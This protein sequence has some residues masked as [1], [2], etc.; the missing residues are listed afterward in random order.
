MAEKIKI[1]EIKETY[2]SKKRVKTEN[3][4]VRFEETTL[5]RYKDVPTVTGG[6][7]FGH[8][9][10]DMVIYYIFS[11]IIAVPIVML[12]MLCGFDINSFSDDSSMNSIFDRLLSWLA[13]YPGYYILFESTIQ[14]TPGKIILGRIVVNE[15]GEKPSFKTILLRSYS[16]IVPFEAFSCLSDFGWHDRWTDTFVIRKKDLHELQLAIKMQKFGEDASK[17]PN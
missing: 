12:L 15:Y 13:L 16:R 9:L 10:L 4:E 14:S 8:H 3:N 1:T 2:R 6:A 7:R 11:I 5:T 17:N